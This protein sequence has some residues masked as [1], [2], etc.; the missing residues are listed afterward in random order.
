MPTIRLQKKLG[1]E[2]KPCT[3]YDAEQLGKYS[4]G[5]IIKAKVSKPRAGWQHRKLWSMVGLVWENQEVYPTKD[6]LMTQIKFLTGNYT[7]HLSQRMHENGEITTKVVPIAD[8]IAYDAMSQADFEQFYESAFN[9]VLTH[10]LPGVD[11][12][13]LRLEV[14]KYIS[15]GL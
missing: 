7:K 3:E 13:D 2:W 8:S 4:I 14:E 5:D 6:A 1:N 15:G 11:A 9:A 10:I 12:N